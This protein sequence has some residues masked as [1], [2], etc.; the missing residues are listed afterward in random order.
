MKII[1]AWNSTKNQKY[2]IT[3]FYQRIII[4]NENHIIQYDNYENH[5]N[6]R[7]PNENNENHEN[8][9]IAFE[10]QTLFGRPQN[11]SR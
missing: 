10:N 11:S 5:E 1:K 7:I 2:L 6:Y 3:E 8:L 4:N 9:R